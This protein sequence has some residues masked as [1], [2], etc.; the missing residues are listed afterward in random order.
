VTDPIRLL[1][2]RESELSVDEVFALVR[3]PQAGGVAIFV[4]AVRDHDHGK[5]VTGLD[6]TAHPTVEATLH[7]VAAEVVEAYDVLALAAV[8]RVGALAIGDLAVVVAVACPHRGDAFGAARQLID[9]LK[10]RVRI[11][12]HQ[13][14]DDGTEEW[15]GAP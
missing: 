9:E 12:K 8:H 11:W 7:E 4:G 2:I 13:N 10:K 5:S 6:Y 1:E 14:F 15:V 3:H